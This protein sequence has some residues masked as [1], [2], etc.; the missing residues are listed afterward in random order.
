[1]NRCA[2]RCRGMN[3]AREVP[4]FAVWGGRMNLLKQV[5]PLLSI[6]LQASS[7]QRHAQHA[8]SRLA[9]VKTSAQTSPR[10]H[11]E[12]SR[13]SGILARTPGG[14]K[15]LTGREMQGRE[16]SGGPV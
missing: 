7:L 2:Q 4:R 13:C 11:H 15:V 14:V 9:W 1:M 10:N 5:E 3:R 8:T 6:A 12:Q 16:P